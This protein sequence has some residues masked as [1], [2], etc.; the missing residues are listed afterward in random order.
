MK[1][2][3]WYMAMCCM[4]LLAAACNKQ[5]ITDNPEDRLAFSTDTLT[6][7]T[8][9]TTL[10]SSTRLFKI[11]NP[12]NQ[13]IRISTIQ[14]E[15]GAASPFRINVD[16]I[17]GTRFSNVEIAANDSIYL[18]AEVTVD[19]GNVNNPF[20]IEDAVVFETN[21]NIQKVQLNAYGQDAYFYRFNELCTTQWNNDKPHVI[22][23]NILI[24]TQCTLTVTQGARIY[25]AQ[26]ANILVAGTLKMLGAKDSFI[27]VE[28]IRQE[29]FFDNLPGQW[30]QIIFLRGSR[31]NLLQFTALKE[32]TSGVVIGSS[33]SN[34]LADFSTTNLPDVTLEQVSIAQM[35]EYGI[36]SFFA[37]VSALNTLITACGQNNVAALFGGTHTYTHCTLVNYG[38]TGLEH[39]LPVFKMS[40][41]ALQSQTDVRVRPANVTV[42]NSIIDGNLP[43]DAN[44]S[45]GEIQIDT[46]VTT[47][48]FNYQFH[49]CLLRT[50]LNVQTPDFVQVTTNATP[51]FE[52][53]AEG[54]FS[55]TGQSPALNQ[56]DPAFLPPIDLFGTD[57][58]GNADLGAVA[59]KK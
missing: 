5:R 14:L 25:V 40:N 39:K 11:F 57:R 31:N 16:G 49:H 29:S 19:P 4:V 37:N 36:F 59:R 1:R 18:F 3:F 56:A 51:E 35:Q 15:G 41:Y 32:G 8:V 20:L 47:V 12:N 28:G 6:F 23:G 24:D 43:G 22:L 9:F 58:Q 27:T 48:P 50:F 55:L 2:W 26:D 44:T 30:G 13:R 34:Q 21:G 38:A 53:A 54:D 7:D 17:S 42:R 33:T 45:L 46:V 52:N 10:G